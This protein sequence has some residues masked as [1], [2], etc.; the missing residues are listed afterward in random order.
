MLLLPTKMLLWTLPRSSSSTKK[1][2]V[3]IAKGFLS[4]NLSLPSRGKKGENE[5]EELVL[6][7]LN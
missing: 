1:D 7:V 6:T 3:A 4:A 5:K 2:V